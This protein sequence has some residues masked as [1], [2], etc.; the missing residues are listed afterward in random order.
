MSMM[1]LISL[2]PVRV[3]NFFGISPS[4]RTSPHFAFVPHVYVQ[5]W[6]AL[7]LIQIKVRFSTR[8]PD[9]VRNRGGPVNV[10]SGSIAPF[11]PSARHFRSAP[12]NGHQQTCP[13]G[14]VRATSDVLNPRTIIGSRSSLAR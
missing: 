11:R 6:S 8:K 1:L 12:I 10:A 7:K 2:M 13:V 14:P 5:A 9:F 4:K 3:T